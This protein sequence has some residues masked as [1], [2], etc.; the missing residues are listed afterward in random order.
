MGHQGNEGGRERLPEKAFTY[1]LPEAWQ[2]VCSQCGGSWKFW[3]LE[4]I[5]RKEKKKR[6][7]GG[8]FT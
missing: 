4:F 1:S 8:V 2:C 3:L 7:L 6:T 5:D